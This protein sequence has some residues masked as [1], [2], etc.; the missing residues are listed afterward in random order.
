MLIDKLR[1][2]A[3]APQSSSAVDKVVKAVARR[4]ALSDE[5]EYRVRLVSNELLNNIVNHSD[6]DEI[7]IS[8]NLVDGVLRLTIAD[9]GKGFR[10]AELMQQDVS[11]ERCLYQESGRGIFLVRTVADSFHYNAAGNSVEVELDLN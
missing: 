1:I 8:A 4:H 7:L 6:A 10:Y 3:E 2:A 5:N 11:G 9:N